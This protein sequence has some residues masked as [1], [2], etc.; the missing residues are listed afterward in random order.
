MGYKKIQVKL[1][2]N[3][4]D[5]HIK[6]IIKDR[7]ALSDFTYVIEKKSLDARKKSHIHWQTNLVISSPALEGENYTLPPSLEIPYK[8]RNETVI[9][10]GSGPAG[11][12]SAHVLQKAGFDVSIVERGSDVAKRDKAI[13]DLEKNKNFS[14]NNNYAFGEGGAGTFSDGKLTSRS[15]HIS[16]E[17]QFILQEYVKA[18]APEE[19]MYMAHP[20]LGTDNLKRIV[21]NLRESFLA[22]GGNILFDTHMSDIHIKNG[23]AQ[24]IESSQGDISADH[25]LLAPGHSAYDTYRMLIKRGVSFHTKQFAIGHRI[26]HPRTLINRIQ[27]GG[28]EELPGVKAAE[29]RLTTKTSS[30]LPVYTFCMCPGGQVVQSATFREKNIVN[31]M[32]YYQRNGQFS[33]AAC[34]TGIH[35]DVLLGHSCTP[36]EILDWMDKLEEKFYHYSDDY[37]IPATKASDYI[38]KRKSRNNFNGSYALGLYSGALYN[39]IPK[40][41]ST[42]LTQG[43]KNFNGMMKGFD[44]GILMG[45]ESK[46]SSPLQ[47]DRDKFGLCQGYDNLYIIGEASGYAGGIISSAADGIRCAMKIITVSH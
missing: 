4:K 25:V 20:H 7:F 24:G 1:P 16:K 11:F 5:D 29:Y 46:T 47:A 18:G 10:I 35:P 32:S 13:K 8:K 15:K 23:H 27:W 36:N 45:L 43:L 28:H 30:G 12:F 6:Q 21:K 34:V 41:V 26:E 33:N 31:G 9:V 14:E 37:S 42:A 19:I 38:K 44:Q 2:T 3:F 17:R 40:A 22:N 39:M